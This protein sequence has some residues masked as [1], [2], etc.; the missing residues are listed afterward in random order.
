MKILI[1]GGTNGMGKG[2]AKILAGQG[3]PLNEVIILCR[4][5]SLGQNTVK[6][7][8]SATL[9]TNISFVLCDLGRLAD[10]KQ[11]IE[12]IKSKHNYLDG[13]FINAGLGYAAR[14][15]ET[16]NGLDAHFRVNY[17]SQFIL[18]LNLLILLE[19][20]TEGGRVIFNVIEH[21]KIF[22]EDL[23]L[24]NNWSYKKA[25]LQAMVAKRLFVQKL[26]QLYSGEKKPKISFIGFE[27]P[28]TVRTNQITIIPTSIRIMATIMKWFGQF[29]SME[30]CGEIIAPLFMDSKE[31]SMR[32]SGKFIT[33]KHG[34]FTEI[35]DDNRIVNQENIDR[36]WEVSLKLCADEKT[37]QIAE[38][39]QN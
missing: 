19:Q 2:V 18:V 8:Q 22:W 39:L 38:V 15:V 30:R 3:N 7:L 26:H 34:S 11:V 4:N 32:K 21:G 31:E 36:L 10:V 16:E 35:K 5:Q 25:L 29:I 17:L 13:I 37:Q 28:K 33:L 24:K 23:Q 1:T 20:S 27:I 9:N 12:E 6:E 14:H